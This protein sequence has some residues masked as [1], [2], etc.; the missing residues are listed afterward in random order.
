MFFIHDRGHMLSVYLF[1]QQLGSILGLISGGSIA[2][3]VGWRW[4]Q[5]IVA[6]IDAVVF[7][8]LFF[9]F[10]ETMFPRFLFTPTIIDATIT[11]L[12]DVEEAGTCVAKD[13]AKVSAE[14]GIALPVTSHPTEGQALIDPFPK[15]TYIQMLD[16][17]YNI[18]RTRPVSGSISV[19]LSSSW[20]IPMLSLPGSSLPL[21]ALLA[22]CHS[23]PSL[24]SSPTS[25]TT[26]APQPLALFSLLP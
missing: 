13:S 7:V 17:G 12:A 9:T 16:L 24:K 11:S 15:R 21:V 18:L 2:D 26:S 14:G 22:L 23:T 20:A 19:V 6:I 4:S 1:G 10:E 5:Y 3:T 25:H 8:L